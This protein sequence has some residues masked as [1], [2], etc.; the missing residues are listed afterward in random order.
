[1]IDKSIIF[2]EIDTKKKIFFAYFC[3]IE[4]NDYVMN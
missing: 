3:R 4:T 1:M 2:Y